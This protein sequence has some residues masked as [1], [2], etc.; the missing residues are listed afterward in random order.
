MEAPG[1]AQEE[2]AAPPVQGRGGPF[3]TEEMHQA[4]QMD[5]PGQQWGLQVQHEPHLRTWL[6]LHHSQEAQQQRQEEGRRSQRLGACGA[7]CLVHQDRLRRFWKNLVP[8]L[9]RG[10]LCEETRH[11]E[12][13]VRQ[14][15]GDL[16]EDHGGQDTEE[17]DGLDE[18][19]SV[20][21]V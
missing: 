12:P 8:V 5:C 18:G 3:G 1:E 16:Q 2:R 19:S 7:G 20:R 17:R 14:A 10:S 15:H 4:G 13:Q 21:G 11:G 9:Q 6:Q